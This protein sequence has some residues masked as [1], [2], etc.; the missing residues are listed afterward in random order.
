[1]RAL[2]LFLLAAP[3][4]SHAGGIYFSDRPG[5]NTIK[6]FEFGATMTRTVGSASDP[7]GVVFDPVTE[8]VYYAD[9][10]SAELN[11]YAAAGGSPQNH[12]TGLLNVADLRSDRV[13]RVFYWCEESGGLIRKAAFT[14]TGDAGQTVYSGLTSPY[15]LDVD[16][17]EGRLFWSQNGVSL[18]RGPLPGGS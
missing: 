10:G 17:A 18:F 11:S 4:I 15:Y 1:M 9:R 5:T 12:L 16:V 7:R 3:C 2:L 8:R 6:A 14:A 13:N